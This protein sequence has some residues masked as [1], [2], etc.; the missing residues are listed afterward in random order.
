MEMK[1]LSILHSE[2]MIPALGVCELM[3]RVEVCS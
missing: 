1:L 3:A 2:L